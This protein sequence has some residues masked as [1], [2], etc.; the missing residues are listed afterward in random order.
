MIIGILQSAGRC[1]V[2]DGQWP[3][4][5]SGSSTVLLCPPVDPAGLGATAECVVSIGAAPS[6]AALRSQVGPGPA[7]FRAVVTEGTCPGEGAVALAAEPGADE[8]TLAAV[9]AALAWVGTVEVVT[10][11]VLDAVA[12]VV[13]GGEA[14]LSRA[15]DGLVEGAV[16][17]GMPREQA[18]TFAHHTLLA[19]ALLV[20]GAGSP[21][22]LKDQV[23]SPGGT[24]IA[25]LASLED[26]AIRGAYMRAVQAAA[27]ESRARRYAARPGVVE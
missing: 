12:A 9:K 26:A 1:P 4:S 15:L 19:T 23:A 3:S 25:A 11:D 13:S 6:F 2:P 27:Q 7:L 24:T 16:R 14:Y 10:E 8:D 21:A 5:P 22:D 20:R 17:D 18:E